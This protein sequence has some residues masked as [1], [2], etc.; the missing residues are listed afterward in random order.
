VWGATAMILG[1]F[2]CLFD[3]DYCPPRLR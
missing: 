2:A 3:P 1:E